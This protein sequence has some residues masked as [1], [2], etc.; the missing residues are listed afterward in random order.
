M[1][2]VIFV[3]Q[4]FLQQ[5]QKKCPTIQQDKYKQFLVFPK[6]EPDTD[7]LML[8]QGSTSRLPMSVENTGVSMLNKAIQQM[9][10]NPMFMPN[11]QPKVELEN[12]IT[13]LASWAAKQ[14]SE[15]P[16]QSR[17]NIAQKIINGFGGLAH[18]WWH[19]ALTE[20]V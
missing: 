10:A 4:E 8:T 5:V 7:T 12:A 15:D 2:E 16:T 13:L 1:D 3:S 6:V 17:R 19:Y 9:P 11:Y 18:T 14:I 20:Q